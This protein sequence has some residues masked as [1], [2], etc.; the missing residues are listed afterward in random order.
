MSNPRAAMSVATR[1]RIR[2]SLKSAR[3]RVRAPWLLLPW[4]ALERI[5][6]SSSVLVILF[7]PCL[8]RENTK[9]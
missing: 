6:A 5:P 1:I 3:A 7:A 8:V 9:A 2:P 4:I